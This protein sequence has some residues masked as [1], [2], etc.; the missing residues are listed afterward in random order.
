MPIILSMLD[1]SFYDIEIRLARVIGK[2]VYEISKHDLHLK[3]MDSFIKFFIT[4]CNNKE[5]EIR[6]QGIYN[7][8]CF[9]MLFKDI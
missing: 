5:V 6:R 1:I 3:Y 4:I 8:A 2:I 9:N 7:L